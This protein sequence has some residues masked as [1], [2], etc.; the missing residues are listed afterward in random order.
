VVWGKTACEVLA[1]DYVDPDFEFT[2][3]RPD[4]FLDFLHRRDGE[5]EIYFVANR[6]GRWEEVQAKFRVLG[7]RPELWDP[8]TG[9][10]RP[11]TAYTK[12]IG[13]TTLPLEL[14]PFGS[15][16]VVFRQAIPANQNGSGTK[17][18][19]TF[20]LPHELAGPWTVKFDPKWGGPASVR[21]ETL[22]DWT[23]RPEAGIRFF[24]GT[25]V[26]Q[27]TFDLPEALRTSGRRLVLDLGEVKELASVRLNGKDLGILWAMPLRV[28]ITEAVKPAG[29]VLEIA[30]TNFWPN[31]LIG[32]A[33]LP[34][35]KRF[36]RTTVTLKKDSPL[37]PSGLL[38]PV[39][40]MG[41]Q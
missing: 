16:F 38:G 11:A 34:P 5:T 20:S 1:A 21:F 36:T 33:A 35:D 8:L 32:D 24:S 2:A 4:A 29:N 12:A 15:I 31:R 41:V 26:Y 13:R 25:A 40:L 7:K 6:L 18:S 10:I 28:E 17:N 3:G 30:V 9:E 39:R 27:K 37:M 19:P 14:A 23:T 22:V